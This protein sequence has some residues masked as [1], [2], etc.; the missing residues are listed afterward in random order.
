MPSIVPMPWRTRFFAASMR[1]LSA[2]ALEKAIEIANAL[3]EDGIA[4]GKAIV[5]AIAQAKCSAR[6][7]GLPTWGNE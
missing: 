6:N 4:K 5:I 3:L 1:L 2:P 7:H